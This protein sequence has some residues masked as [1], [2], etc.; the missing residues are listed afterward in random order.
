MR[1][2]IIVQTHRADNYKNI[3]GIYSSEDK[4]L[5]VAADL[6]CFQQDSDDWD[7]VAAPW[8]FSVE[9]HVVVE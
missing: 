8:E 6:E 3:V 2:Y 4:A 7:S 1:V 9:K 5:E